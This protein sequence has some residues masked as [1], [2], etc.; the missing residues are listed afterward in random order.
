MKKIIILL[1][2][3]FLLISHTILAQGTYDDTPSKKNDE[4]KYNPVIIGSQI[5]M[6]DNLDLSTFQNGDRIPEVND[7]VTWVTNGI[8]QKPASCYS[9]SM[10]YFNG[11]GKLYNWY[12]ANDA[13]GICPE[14]WSVP[15]NKDWEQLINY[16]GGEKEAFSKLGDSKAWTK[17]TFNN[18]S[19]FTALPAGVR[20]E[21]N[22]GKF[23]AKGYATMWWSSTPSDDEYGSA[24]HLNGYYTSF[25]RG[26]KYKRN[27][28]SIRCIKK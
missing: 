22:D 5:W 10:T 24:F 17:G 15:D 25:V 11:Y 8:I 18:S 23:S 14:G 19:G 7:D 9:E 13:R 6:R 26:D 20:N 2:T 3:T 4:T 16:L 12:A 1:I 27:G 21:S 28:Y